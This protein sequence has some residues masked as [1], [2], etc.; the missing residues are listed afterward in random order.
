LA[1]FNLTKNLVILKIRI[2][3]QV[4]VILKIRSSKNVNELEDQ[5]SD[6][7]NIVILRSRS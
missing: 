7:P 6:H 4:L 3:D 2:L 1:L 5:R